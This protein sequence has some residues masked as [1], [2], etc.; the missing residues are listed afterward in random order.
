[1]FLENYQSLALILPRTNQPPR[2]IITYGRLHVI[3]C[4]KFRYHDL[5]TFAARSAQTCYSDFRPEPQNSVMTASLSPKAFCSNIAYWPD[6][7]NFLPI[8]NVGLPDETMMRC[9]CLRYQYIRGLKA[10][11]LIYNMHDLCE[12]NNENDEKVF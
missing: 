5:N 1:M 10:Q 11:R 2:I 8:S 3:T 12:W 6:T 4:V 7:I 9:S